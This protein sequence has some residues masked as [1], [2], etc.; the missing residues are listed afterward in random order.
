MANRIDPETNRELNKLSRHDAAAINY[1]S[2][3]FPSTQPQPKQP[4]DLIVSLTDAH[5]NVRARQVT[6]WERMRELNVRKK[7]AKTGTTNA[8]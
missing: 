3:A 4:D 7:P 6:E 2:E 1:I 5:E 8:V